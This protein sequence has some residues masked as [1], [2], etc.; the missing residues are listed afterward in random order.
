M[1]SPRVNNVPYDFASLTFNINGLRITSGLRSIS[2]E[3]GM[4]V[5]KLMG[6]DREAFDRTGGTYNAEDSEVTLYKSTYLAV[7]GA[8]GPGYMLPDAEFGASLSYGKD[9]QEVHTVQFERARIIK[10]AG[11]HSQGTEGLEVSITLSVMKIKPDGIDPVK[12]AA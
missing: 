7:I 3:H 12:R 6:A 11:D 10:D 2:W 9:G 1:A 8:L 4:E 5:E